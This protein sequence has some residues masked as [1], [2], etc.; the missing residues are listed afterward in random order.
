MLTA[1]PKIWNLPYHMC[2]AGKHEDNTD[3]TTEGESKTL[4][5]PLSH[6]FQQVMNDRTFAREENQNEQLK[7]CWSRFDSSR[8]GINHWG[9]LSRP[10]TS[11]PPRAIVITTWCIGASPPNYS[12]FSAQRWNWYG[13]LPISTS[14][15]AT[16]QCRTPLRRS[17]D[18]CRGEKLLPPLPPMSAHCPKETWT[19][20]AH[21]PAHHRSSIQ[22]SEHG[23]GGSPDKICPRAMSTSLSL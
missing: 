8:A 14:W 6:V 7:H 12:L 19:K 1:A 4:T 2:L 5:N 17:R 18:E 11:C 22:E 16:W 21:S 10:P 20:T 13:I 23:Y 15:V 9:R 3:R